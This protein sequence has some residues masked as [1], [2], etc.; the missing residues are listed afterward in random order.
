MSTVPV[1]V[2][3]AAGFPAARA[4]DP[5]STE[6]ALIACSW[7]TCWGVHGR[8]PDNPR[9]PPLPPSTFGNLYEDGSLALVKR[10]GAHE[11]TLQG[12][13]RS[14]LS[15]SLDVSGKAWTVTPR[16]TRGLWLTWNWNQKR[17]IP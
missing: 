7:R 16:S 9:D 14:G 11:I 8:L 13:W 2:Q 12:V 1:F 17:R 4:G 15:G 6:C 10:F 5:P 3:E